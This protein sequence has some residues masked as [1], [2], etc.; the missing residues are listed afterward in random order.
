MSTTATPPVSQFDLET[1]PGQGG[2]GEATG[3]Y[4]DRIKGGD[5]G[6]V[7]AIFGAVVLVIVFGIMEPDSFLTANNFANL[8][9]QGAAITVLA[10]GLVFV[11]LLGE[12][13][14]SAGFTAGTGA[15]ILAVTLTNKGWAW[16]LAILA[17]L[18]VGVAIGL[19]IALLVARLG[20]PS[21]VVSL[22]FFLG[23]Q[24]A[25]LLIIGE[26]GTIPIRNEAVLKVMNQNMSVGLGWLFA[27]VVIAG[28][29]G[30]TYWAIMTRKKAGLPTMALS[31]WGAKIGGLAIVVLIAVFLLNQE[32]QRAS[33]PIVIQGVPW[34]VPLV[35]ALV[36]ALS[37]LL[38]RTS[39]GR[40]VYAV[41]GNAE[42]ARRAGINVANIKTVCF[43]LGSTL[44]IV[45]GILLA[46]RDNSVSP[47]TGGAQTLLYA[48]GAAV[49]GG[50]SLFGGR[51]KIYDA[52]TG[53]LVVAIIANGLPLVTQK[54]G[55]QFIINGLV[56]LLAASVDA[57]S[58][59]R[60]AATGR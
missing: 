8:I 46:S 59:R 10:M 40:H 25:M 58:R 60:A 37:F 39:F 44:A 17:A 41:G 34:V 23:L 15:A 31:V 24:G 5:L 27:I 48:V 56:L 16:P 52:V 55:V 11:L 3:A 38:M 20:I 45:A 47:T 28:F 33:A 50:T 13:D 2:L 12:I 32:R 53:G 9:N 57:I 43:I 36:V 19:A 26:G 1:T 35:A 29:A 21:F 6:A 42:A 51:G 18:V 30:A 4:W 49:I 7:P 54:S 14:L 22:A